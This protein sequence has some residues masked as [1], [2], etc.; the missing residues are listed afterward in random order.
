MNF[1]PS[2]LE[3]FSPELYLAILSQVAHADG[4]HPSEA[5]L[6]NQQAENFGVKLTELPQVPNDLSG[7]PW[8]TRILVYRDALMLSYAD[9]QLSEQEQAH[10]SNLAER[11]QLGE[12]T[13]S[14]IA[15]WVNDYSNLLNRLEIIL[16]QQ[17]IPE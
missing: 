2:F 12:S 11:L 13:T 14:E 15:A 8:Q 3:G 17:S 4:L 16:K 1:L 5:A 7:V 6:L 10:L 9:G